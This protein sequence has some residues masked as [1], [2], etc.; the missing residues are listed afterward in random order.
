MLYASQQRGRHF[1]APVSINGKT[2]EGIIDTGAS[3]VAMST[4]AARAFGIN[5]ANG[6]PGMA[7]TANGKIQTYRVVVPQVDVAGIKV[8][9]VP[10]TVGITGELLVGMSF[11]SQLDVSMTSDT[12][13]MKKR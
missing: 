11:L 6:T 3:M 7:S 2:V 10:V 9:N 1:F 5:Y 8:K 12:L 4:D 13:T